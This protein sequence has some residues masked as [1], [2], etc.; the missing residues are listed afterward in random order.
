MSIATVEVRSFPKEGAANTIPE[1]L[2]EVETA[3]CRALYGPEFG[4]A[5][6]NNP[7]NPKLK[8]W[9]QTLTSIYF[10]ITKFGTP[11]AIGAHRPH[12]LANPDNIEAAIKYGLINGAA[13]TPEVAAEIPRLLDLEGENVSVID[14][15][16]WEKAN[17][18]IIS[19]KE[20]LTH[21]AANLI[22][23]G[24]ARTEEYIERYH[25]IAVNR[26][27]IGVWKN[28]DFKG[29][30]VARLGVFSDYFDNDGIYADS[31]LDSGGRF[32]GVRQLTGAEG[33]AP[34][35]KVL[36]DLVGKGT[37]VGNGLV[38]VKKDQI[39][40]EAYNLLKMQ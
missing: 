37:D 1:A 13:A 36:E 5:R 29:T 20:A 14:Y 34:Q 30:R 23:G 3:G 26:E 8:D 32:A 6:I 22:L 18:G 16:D 12:Y 7:T 4:K 11:V 27:Q 40:P 25:K 38:V 9:H 39:S 31:S 21:P 10:G 19:L 15:K 17:S 2:R 33:A 24:R 35:V 28:N